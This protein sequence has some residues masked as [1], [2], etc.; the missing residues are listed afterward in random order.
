MRALLSPS[1]A[2]LVIGCS[3]QDAPPSSE[4]APRAPRRDAVLSFSIDVD[5]AAGT[6]VVATRA[7]ALLVE[8]NL[9]QDG[10]PG[11]GP[12]DSFELVTTNV[13]LPGQ[14]DC[15]TG[16][17]CFDVTLRSFY[18]AESFDDLYMQ[19]DAITP[20]TGRAIVNGDPPPP[21]AG[22]SSPFGGRLFGTVGPG[23][24]VLRDVRVSIP[25]L[26]PYRVTGRLFH[27]AVGAP[28][29]CPTS[30]ACRLFAGNAFAPRIHTVDLATGAFT[31]TLTVT[32]AGVTVRGVTALDS[33]PVTGQLYAALKT[34]VGRANRVVVTIDKS[35]GVATPL[36]AFS[37]APIASLAFNGDGTTL[38]AGIGERATTDA[39]TLKA[40]DL[41]NGTLGPVLASF[42][43]GS[44]GECIAF[45]NYDGLIYH[46][47]GFSDAD[48]AFETVDP[49]NG[50]TL[51]VITTT[52]PTPGDEL[53]GMA[54]D[55][56]TGGFIAIGL[57]TVVYALGTDATVTPLTD[58]AAVVLRDLT[59]SP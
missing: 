20:P 32:L 31:S 16:R 33:H 48:R 19:I 10:I 8:G 44:D 26:S 54:F 23:G 42:G 40:V 58:Y 43:N 21:N 28:Q 2:V 41:S 46:A 6:A 15:A 38:W 35:T 4:S 37:G 24:A 27:E 9:V 1:L 51:D 7:S 56:D 22:I 11:S 57:Q 29:A 55:P 3:A 49:A 13:R 34:S 5:P 45:N 47:S 59:L 52:L 12:L 14:G 30:G 25:D 53:S 17:N 50:F 39:M 18:D 36:G